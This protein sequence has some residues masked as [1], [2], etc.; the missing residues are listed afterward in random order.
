MKKKKNKSRIDWQAIA[1]D[2]IVQLTIGI[3]L[4]LI[5]KLLG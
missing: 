4:A 3:I 5:Q 1:I 2:A